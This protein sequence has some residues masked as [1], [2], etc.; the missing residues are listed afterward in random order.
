MM[1]GPMFQKGP[2]WMLGTFVADT[3]IM[4]VQA[5]VVGVGGVYVATL[6]AMFAHGWRVPAAY[7]AMPGWYFV[8]SL[9]FALAGYVPGTLDL[10]GWQ[11]WNGLLLVLSGSLNVFAMYW[12]ARTVE[13]NR[14][15]E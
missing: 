5:I 7:L 8:A 3:M 4:N 13:R 15:S 10:L 1:A 12:I 2:N 6:A 9:F 14:A 11:T